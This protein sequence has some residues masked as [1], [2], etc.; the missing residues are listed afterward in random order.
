MAKASI[1][2]IPPQKRRLD[3]IAWLIQGDDKCG[4]AF[5]DGNTLRLATNAPYETSLVKA[6]KIHLMYIA[7]IAEELSS[8]LDKMPKELGDKDITKNI[9]QFKKKVDKSQALWKV[10]IEKSKLYNGN[11]SFR[12][13]V[14]DAIIKITNSISASFIKESNHKAFPIALAYAIRDGRIVYAGEGPGINREDIHAEMRLAYDLLTNLKKS[15]LEIYFGTSKKC[16]FTCEAMI[17]AIEQATEEIEKRKTNIEVREPGHG[18]NFPAAIP[19]F[20]TEPAFSESFRRSLVINFLKLI[21]KD[22]KLV[23]DGGTLEVREIVTDIEAG[24]EG[25]IEILRKIY[26]PPKSAKKAPMI[27]LP[28]S[29]SLSPPTNNSGAGS[30]I[31]ENLKFECLDAY[32]AK[33]QGTGQASTTLPISSIEANSLSPSTSSRKENKKENVSTETYSSTIISATGK[34]ISSSFTS[35]SSEVSI[36]RPIEGGSPPSS[37]PLPSF[38]FTD[39]TAEFWQEKSKAFEF[40]MSNI[41]AY[42]DSLTLKDSTE[43]SPKDGAQKENQKHKEHKMPHAPK[44]VPSNRSYINKMSPT[45]EDPMEQSFVKKHNLSPSGQQ[46]RS[47]AISSP[48]KAT[49][50]HPRVSQ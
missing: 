29:R 33:W 8:N 14:D 30:F 25:Y 11:P 17:A 20:I 23:V 2:K 38:T 35:S 41:I 16:C 22:G 13:D 36:A 26:E 28:R 24:K 12:N 1:D 45:S 44:S 39:S 19:Q 31:H 21:A 10:E 50:P 43:E 47:S 48:R 15:N 42:L 40:N 6:T 3:S 18:K 5:F 9:E 4:A 7:K 46:S 49:Y 37:K 34:P 27:N 32:I